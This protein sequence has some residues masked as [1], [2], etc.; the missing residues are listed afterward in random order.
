MTLVAHLAD[1][2]DYVQDL[3]QTFKVTILA[4]PSGYVP[5]FNPEVKPER[6]P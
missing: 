1:Y 4:K 2:S 3:S 5:D 6:E